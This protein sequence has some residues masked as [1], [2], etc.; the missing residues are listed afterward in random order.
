MLLDDSSLM[1][2][3]NKSVLPELFYQWSSYRLRLLA[4]RFRAEAESLD[5]AH[6]KAV[7]GGK[8]GEEIV[9]VE[10]L[11]EWMDKQAV[12]MKRTV[13]EMR[14]FAEGEPDGYNEILEMPM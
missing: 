4:E 6:R 7:Q 12:Y 5:R 13:F 8:K 3:R 9:N 1:N 14:P 2:V 11:R 10:R